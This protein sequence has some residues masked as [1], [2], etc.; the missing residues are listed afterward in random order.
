MRILTAEQFKKEPYGTVYIQFMPRVYMN[1]PRIKSEARGE[2]GDSWWALDI[3][4]WVIDDEEFDKLTVDNNYELK[5][6][7]YCTDDAI[8]NHK[9]DIQYAV[10][11]KE[12]IKGMIDRL[13]E[14]L[15]M[16]N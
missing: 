9:S 13:T 16:I 15:N 4:P 6:E 5:T 12:E 14:S 7:G 2:S 10:F 1:E 11:N 3:L 8:Y